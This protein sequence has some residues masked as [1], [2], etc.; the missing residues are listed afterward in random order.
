MKKSSHHSHH[1]T[2]RTPK[3]HRVDTNSSHGDGHI[4]D[5]STTTLLGAGSKKQN[6]SGRHKEK[7]LPTRGSEN[8]KQET[9]SSRRQEEKPP[10]SNHPYRQIITTDQKAHEEK[11]KPSK[12]TRCPTDPV[13]RVRY[14]YYQIEIE[15]KLGKAKRELQL[16]ER[17][18]WRAADSCVPYIRYIRDLEELAQEIKN[19]KEQRL[20]PGKAKKA[21]DELLEI[22]GHLL[23]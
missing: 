7:Y 8:R 17:Y 5:S 15:R 18:D 12:S 4:S 10:T 9:S 19:I 13:A 21:L 23:E 11:Q 3:A 6:L 20:A 14:K 22:R 1:S 2:D 16:E